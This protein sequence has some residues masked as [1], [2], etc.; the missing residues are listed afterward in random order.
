ME[1]PVKSV[2]QL[3]NVLTDV[4]IIFYISTWTLAT[5]YV[6]YGELINV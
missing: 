2:F 5:L 3:V 4:K 6:K 1:E